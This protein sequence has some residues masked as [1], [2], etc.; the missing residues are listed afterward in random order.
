M[1]EAEARPVLDPGKGQV[2]TVSSR[3]P[4]PMFPRA[5]FPGIGE[6]LVGRHLQ[7]LAVDDAV[8]GAGRPRLECEALALHGLE[9]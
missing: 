5:A 1:D 4:Y 6:T 2:T 3:E 9:S 7:H 8:P